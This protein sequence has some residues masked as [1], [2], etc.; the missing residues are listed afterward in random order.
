MMRQE[1]HGGG[2]PSLRFRDNIGIE[3][4]GF[5]KVRMGCSPTLT[6]YEPAASHGD[7][8]RANVF[9]FRTRVMWAV[10]VSSSAAAATAAQDGSNVEIII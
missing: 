8:V 4:L 5:Q 9:E 7:F 10:H 1:E 2:N 3:K 6:K